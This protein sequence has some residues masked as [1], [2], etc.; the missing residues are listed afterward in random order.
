[1]TVFAWIVVGAITLMRIIAAYHVP[2]TGDEAYYWEWSRHPAFGY[3]DH[4]PMVA[5]TIALFSPLGQTPGAI[6]LGFIVCG[7]IATFAGAAA[8]TDLADGD[9]RAGAVTA[10]AFSLTP[11]FS[12]AFGSAT[13]DGPY[14]AAW[15]VSL[16]L[17]VRAFKRQRPL[18]FV[19]LGI[20]LGAALLTR[21]FA[22]ALVFGIAMYAVAPARR[23]LYRA[24]LGMSLAIAAVVYAPFI[25]WNALHDWVTFDFTFVGR[26]VA[27]LSWRGPLTLYAI[28]A[29]AYSPGLWIGALVCAVRPRSALLAWTA[30]PL[31]GLLSV[32]AFIEPV[33]IHWVFGPYA[34]LCVA[35]GLAYV[36][37]SSRMRVVWASA[38]VVPALILLPMIFVA[39]VAPGPIYQAF[40]NTGS[41]LRNTGPFEIFTFWPLAQDVKKIADK[42]DAIV[43]TDGYGLSSLLDFDAGIAPVVIGYNWQGRESR[44]WYPADRHPTR[45]LF[46]DKE[47]LASRPDFAKQLA[48]A[49]D[50]VT[51]APSLAY[52]Y[53]GVPPRSY[54]LT[55]CEGMKPGAIRLLRWEQPGDERPDVTTLGS[56]R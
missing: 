19:L 17:A 26:H 27:H 1:M 47:T 44:R 15:A 28:N 38:S 21:F 24:G 3:V 9:R 8:A 32:L 42:N 10:V 36:H 49:C 20:A 52:S 31:L 13:P 56:G 18:D 37:L 50:R 45:A 7:L 2:L 40:R 43:M 12:L 41:T 46:V 25:A 4:P 14:L 53:A 35:L 51:A 29:G 55:W 5:W 22:A 54:Y 23:Y 34:S 30:L 48:L 33:E 16:W 6:R 11:L 39:A